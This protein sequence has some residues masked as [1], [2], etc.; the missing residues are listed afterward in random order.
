MQGVV[1]KPE[2]YDPS[3]TYPVIVYFY[4]FFSQRLH[5]FNR[6]QINHRP[7]FPFYTGRD[8][9]VLLPDVVFEVGR[10]GYSATKSLVPAVQKLIDVGITD[11]DRIA[12]HSH[13]RYV[14]QK[15]VAFSH[16][17]IV[18]TAIAGMKQ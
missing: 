4:R 17:N 5:E 14:T 11:Q 15:A 13:S 10:P 2:N 3:R 9:V 7:A 18:S 12:L 6:P 8:Y 1:M 16:T